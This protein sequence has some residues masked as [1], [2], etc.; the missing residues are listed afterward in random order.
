[1]PNL[2]MDKVNEV[3]DNIEVIS[4]SEKNFYKSILEIRYSDILNKEYKKLHLKNAMKACMK[5][6]AALAPE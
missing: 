1:M 4:E 5:Q 6:T 3:I 2:Q